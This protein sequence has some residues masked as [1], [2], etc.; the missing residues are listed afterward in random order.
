MSLSAFYCPNP[1]RRR[2]PLTARDYARRDFAIELFD[3]GDYLAAIAEIFA[4]AMPEVLADRPFALPMQF[5]QGS[6]LFDVRLD[7]DALVISTVLAE[8]VPGANA[9][10]L[11]RFALS[12]LA[13]SGQVWQPRLK[14]N[15][16]R[17]EFRESLPDLHPLKLLEVLLKLPADASQHDQWLAEE[18]QVARPHAAPLGPL[19]AEE[20]A[21]ALRFWRQHWQDMEI[22]HNEVRRRRSVRMLDFVGS[23]ASHLVRVVLPLHGSLRITLDEQADEIADRD[24]SVSK[25]DSAMA[26]LIRS[27]QAVD[28]ARLLASLGHGDYAIN[29][30]REGSPSSIHSLFGA[31][32]RMQTVHEHRANGRLLEAGLELV[33]Y[34]SY[35]LGS[36]SWPEPVEQALL[37]FLTS[38]HEKPIRVVLDSLLK[39][40]EAIANEFGKHGVQSHAE[41]EPAETMP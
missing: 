33:A 21:A 26:K 24:E 39:Q 8:M 34:A 31:G 28:D 13:G 25:R 18:F 40:A 12:R 3:R 38:A 14:A 5:A 11:L 35:L 36:F 22:L 2:R 32:E 9:T 23:L 10:A 37:Q 41:D 1:I 4:H 7:G 30:L 27:M 6:A 16:I 29:P 17:L 15:V 19:S 20:S